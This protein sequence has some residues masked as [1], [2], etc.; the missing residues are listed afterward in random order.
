MSN[1]STNVIFSKIVE[2]LGKE[3]RNER[4]K[5]SETAKE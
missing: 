2:Q 4:A 3:V 1:Q 5:V